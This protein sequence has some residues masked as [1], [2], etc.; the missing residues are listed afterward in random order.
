MAISYKKLWK[1]LMDKY[2]RKGELCEKAQISSNTLNKLSIEKMSM[3][4]L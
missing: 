4:I 3:Q 2:M 1:L